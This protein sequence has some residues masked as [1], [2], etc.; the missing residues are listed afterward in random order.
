MMSSSIT[1]LLLQDYA[2]QKDISTSYMK[3]LSRA[4]FEERTLLL[5]LLKDIDQGLFDGLVV[6]KLSR[7]ARN[8]KYS[9]DI[10]EVL[11]TTIF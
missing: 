3:R 7:I 5:Q 9:Q 4:G 11:K 8:L 6:V 2:N 10:A 1:R